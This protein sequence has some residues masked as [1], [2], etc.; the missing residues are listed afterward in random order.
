MSMVFMF[1]VFL[2][3]VQVFLFMFMVCFMVMHVVLTCPCL[4]TD[5]VVSHVSWFVLESVHGSFA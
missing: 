1:M 3:M 5:Y 4:L 2:V